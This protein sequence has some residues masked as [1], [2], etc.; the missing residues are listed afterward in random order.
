MGLAREDLLTLIARSWTED[1]LL[2]EGLYTHLATADAGDKEFARRQ[3]DAFTSFIAEIDGKGMKPPLLHCAN[4]GAAI[5]IPE[6]HFDMIRPG[7]SVYGYHSSEQMQN[8]PDLRPSM[9][10]IANLALVKSISKGSMVGYG[11][12]YEAEND[13]TIGIVPVG[14]AD[15][16]DR[17]LSNTGMTCVEGRMVPVI[18]R[19]SMDQTIVDLTRL[20]TEGVTM[21]PGHEVIVI[22]NVREQPNSVE[23]LACLLGTIPHEIVSR[24]TNRI[25]RVPA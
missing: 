6:S 21:A 7:I 22:D 17:R 23:S 13:M 19:V 3:L 8:K 5:D 15:G 14:Y 18:G 9:K 25:K 10:V 4:S 24:L 20:T 11:C 2:V 16:Y 1:G 12:T